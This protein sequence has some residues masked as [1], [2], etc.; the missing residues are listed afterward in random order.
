MWYVDLVQHLSRN[1]PYDGIPLRSIFL[2]SSYLET[3]DSL[4]LLRGEAATKRK[5]NHKTVLQ[6]QFIQTFPHEMIIRSNVIKEVN[7]R[8]RNLSLQ[9]PKKCYICIRIKEFGE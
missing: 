4:I 2:L 7:L 8:Q 3:I 9:L 5:K 6:V 1:S